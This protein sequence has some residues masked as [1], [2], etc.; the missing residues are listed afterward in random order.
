MIMHNI[1][2]C[3]I[4]FIAYN[5]YHFIFCGNSTIISI[6]VRPLLSADLV[7][8]RFLRPKFST[9]KYRG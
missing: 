4:N 1:K 5:Q 7:Y 2:F 8:P 6:T 9:P 3:F